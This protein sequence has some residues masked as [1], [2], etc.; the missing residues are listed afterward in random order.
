MEE[1]D[2]RGGQS[3]KYVA[4]GIF[5]IMLGLASS[6]GIY[7]TFKA[8][9]KGPVYLEEQGKGEGGEGELEGVREE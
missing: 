7:W 6:A 4:L 9:P 3:G 5:L 1:R 8:D 2:D